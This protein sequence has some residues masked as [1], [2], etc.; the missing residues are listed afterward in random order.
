MQENNVTALDCGQRLDKYLKKYLNQAPESFIYRMLRKKN[1]TLNGRKARPG[2]LLSEGDSIRFYLSDDTIRKFSASEALT[3]TAARERR[4][5]AGFPEVIYEDDQVLIFNKPCGIL[6]QPDHS[7]SVSMAELVRDYLLAKGMICPEELKTFRPGVSN[8]LD[9]NT[10]GLITAGKTLAAQ[11]ALS[12]V[13]KDR[14]L[15]KYYLCLV[16]GKLT[17]PKKIKGYLHKDEKCNK[18]YV[19][20]QQTSKEELLI[21]TAYEPLLFGRNTTLLQVHLLTGRTHQ[22]RAHLA[23][24]AHPVIGDPKY[25]Q[26]GI[27]RAFRKQYGLEHQLL[28]AWKLLFPQM[29]GSLS[30]LSGTEVTA[31]LP[32]LFRRILSEEAVK[33]NGD[34]SL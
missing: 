9:R 29:P 22:I 27:N 6:S 19:H 8:R 17:S 26:S 30:S 5:T 18:V 2:D 21:E 25:G 28:H 14:S 31:P 20:S 13:F 12:A 3:E 32:E 23:S 24:I 34:G 4:M 11:A 1:I 10:S 33:W 16:A 7:G 15:E